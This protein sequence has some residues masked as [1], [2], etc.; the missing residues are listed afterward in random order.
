MNFPEKELLVKSVQKFLNLD[1][2][3]KD[4]KITWD[5]I[6]KALKISEIQQ[7]PIEL[8]LSEK[9]FNLV[10]QYEVGG[11]K[12]YYNKYLKKPTWPQGASGV[13]IGIGYDLGYNTIEQFDKDWRKLLPEEDFIA[14]SKTIGVKGVSAKQYI[15][16]LS[17][18][19]I[20]WDAALIVFQSNTLPRFIKETLKAFPQADKLHPDAFGALVSLVFNRGGST[21]GDSR[22]EMFNIKALVIKKDYKG[23]A[24]EIR[25]MKR[26]W[27]GK[28]LDGLLVRREDEAKLVENCA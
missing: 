4:G 16:K 11:G 28:G 6:L 25:A 1:D 10:L 17:E 27:V 7:S 13:T 5:A 19:N 21:V 3:G 18:I 15:S 2:D 12:N 8:P 9:A 20:L 14:L 24:K 26:L 22:K 23:I